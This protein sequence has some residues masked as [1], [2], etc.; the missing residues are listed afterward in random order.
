[1]KFADIYSSHGKLRFKEDLFTYYRVWIYKC[2]CA[3]KSQNQLN[4]GATIV[5]GCFATENGSSSCRQNPFV[6]LQVVATMLTEVV[7]T[8]VVAW[9]FCQ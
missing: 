9:L 3:M 6:W 4:S 7:V 1:M 5:S 8:W 2:V